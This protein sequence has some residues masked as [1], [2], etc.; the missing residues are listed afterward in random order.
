[1]RQLK[2]RDPAFNQTKI[3]EEDCDPSEMSAPLKGE[4]FASLVDDNPEWIFLTCMLERPG[5]QQFSVEFENK[6]FKPGTEANHEFQMIASRWAGLHWIT[7]I[8]PNDFEVKAR[9]VASKYGLVVKMERRIGIAKVD[10]VDCL[11]AWDIEKNPDIVLESFPIPLRPNTGV[12]E[13]TMKGPV[14]VVVGL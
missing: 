3:V 7:L 9:E 5:F 10:G 8:F 12:L 4:D 6:Y 2:V 13:S 14:A 1:M 11:G